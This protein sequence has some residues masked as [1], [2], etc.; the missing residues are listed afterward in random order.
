MKK[1][2]FTIR[3]ATKKD[4][5]T[6]VGLRYKLD[7]FEYSQNPFHGKPTKKEA[8]KLIGKYLKSRNYFVFIA[9]VD[10]QP[11]GFS[12]ALVKK[13][14]KGL[15]GVFEA[16]WIEPEYRRQGIAKALS[17]VRLKKLKEYKL[18]SIKIYIRPENKASIAN[19]ESMGGKHT[20]SIYQ[21]DT[22]K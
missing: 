12:A 20:L 10:G 7:M 3:P 13:E 19:I 8:E 2:E 1:L 4:K 21:F 15:R 11:V 14:D 18:A 5:N 9:E 17:Q 22:K 6:L 16:I